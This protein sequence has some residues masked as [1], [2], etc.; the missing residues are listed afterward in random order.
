[1]ADPIFEADLTVRADHGQIYIYSPEGTRDGFGDSEN[2]YLDALDDA[3]QSRRFVGVAGGLVD[4]MT[5]GQWN[6]RTP[7]RVEVWSLEPPATSEEWDHEVDVDLDIPDGTLIFE[8]SGGGGQV[9]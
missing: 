8:A 2:V 1:M 9:Q 5:P 3:T 4:L 6:W 7:M